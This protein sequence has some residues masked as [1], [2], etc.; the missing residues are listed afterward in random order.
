MISMFLRTLVMTAERA[1]GR[2]VFKI[3]Q[4]VSQNVGNFHRRGDQRELIQDGSAVLFLL[5][6]VNVRC[7]C[8]ARRAP[9]LCTWCT[10]RPFNA[11][12]SVTFASSL[13]HWPRQPTR[14]DRELK[15]HF[16][17][18]RVAPHCLLSPLCIPALS[19]PTAHPDRLATCECSHSCTR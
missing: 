15:G 7:T 11:R 9:T 16:F 6:D 2:R 19:N 17:F 1:M 18:L 4:A 12:A 8:K 3:M 13:V 10:L 5:V 14:V